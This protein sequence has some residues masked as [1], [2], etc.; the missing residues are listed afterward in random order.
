MCVSAEADFIAA[1]ALLPIGVATL[2]TVRD[3]DE[4]IIGSLPLLFAAHQFVEGFV[5]LGLEG[6]VSGSLQD[7]AIRIYLLF[8]QVVVPVVVPLGILVLEPDRSRRRWMVPLLLV[9][10][11]VAF[12][13]LWVITAHPV[14]ARALDHVITYTTDA[15][16]GY[17]VATGYVIA[18]CLPALVSTRRHLRWFGAANVAGLTA[19]T[20]VRYSAVTS[21]WCLYAAFASGLILLHLR[22]RAGRPGITFAP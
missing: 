21:V 6:H 1:G 13:L 4:L 19:A 5:W 10:V 14:G 9:G 12:R 8:A 17:V 18:T 22:D 11:A 3:R 2:R 7:A 16:F 15:R 20:V